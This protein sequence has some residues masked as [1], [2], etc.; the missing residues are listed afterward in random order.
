MAELPTKFHPDARLEALAAHDHYAEKSS[1][2]GE[3]FETELSKAIEAISANPE[4]WASYLFGT[5]RYLM[6]RFPFVVV[7]RRRSESIEII[8]VAHGHQKPGYWNKRS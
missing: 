8:A 5:Q 6:R 2:L 7:Y 3:A 4:M 1:V